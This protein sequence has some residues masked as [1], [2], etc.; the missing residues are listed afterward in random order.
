MKQWRLPVQGFSLRP[1][2][3]RRE[4]SDDPDTAEFM[5]A[6]AIVLRRLRQGSCS[7]LR[8][9]EVVKVEIVENP[10]LKRKFEAKRSKEVEEGSSGESLMLFHGTPKENILQIVQYN[11]DPTIINNGRAYGDGVYFSECPEVS[12]GYTYRRRGGG[13]RQFHEN[14][15]G[16]FTLILCE[17]LKGSLPVFKEVHTQGDTGR[18][19]AIVVT[20]VERL[21]PRY[22]VTLGCPNSSGDS[23][24]ASQI[25]GRSSFPRP[26]RLGNFRLGAQS[27][28]PGPSTSVFPSRP[29]AYTHCSQRSST[30]PLQPAPVNSCMTNSPTP[31]CSQ[32][33]VLGNLPS[34]GGMT[35]TAL[36]PTPAFLP[37]PAFPPM[38]A[39]PPIPAPSTPSQPASYSPAITGCTCCGEPGWRRTRCRH[40]SPPPTSWDQTSPVTGSR[41][42]RP[43]LSQDQNGKSSSLNVFSAESAD[44]DDPSVVDP[45]TDALAA[46]VYKVLEQLELKVSE[47]WKNNG[48][49]EKLTLKL[50]SESGV[51]Q[52]VVVPHNLPVRDVL[53]DYCRK[54]GTNMMKLVFDGKT[55]LLGETPKSLG[56]EDGDMVEVMPSSDEREPLSSEAVRRAVSEALGSMSIRRSG[57]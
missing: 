19:S 41:S 24:P 11:F 10:R 15:D 17:V 51:E 39:L 46:A 47:L 48:T 7:N 30:A 22:V 4:F 29:V 14:D 3:R 28:G 1:V 52:E 16:N 53:E 5:K 33:D 44:T 2:L 27:S 32:W 23:G 21:L 20:D 56:M 35:W 40:S 9:F 31:L 26:S 45:V 13:Q 42:P 12:L 8:S 38:L 57:K 54:R 6:E 36:P 25:L 18:A 50:V 43:S 49:G 37:T 55:V 34:L